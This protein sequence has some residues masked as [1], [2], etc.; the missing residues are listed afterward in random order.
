MKISTI[1]YFAIALCSL[2]SIAAERIK[3]TCTLTGKDN[4]CIEKNYIETGVEICLAKDKDGACLAKQNKE[5]YFIVKECTAPKDGKCTA[6]ITLG[7]KTAE[8]TVEKGNTCT[9]RAKMNPS[10]L[11]MFGII[12]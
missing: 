10:I 11:K 7:N 2:S 6:Q 12:K 1:V 5:D 3:E 8:C 4:Q 9:A